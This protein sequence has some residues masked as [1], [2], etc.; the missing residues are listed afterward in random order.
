MMAILP[1]LHAA[2]SKESG[3]GAVMPAFG[4]VEKGSAEVKEN[5]EEGGGVRMKEE[6][7]DMQ[8]KEEGGNMHVKE[9]EEEEEEKE[10][11]TEEE[12][13]EEEQEKPRVKVKKEF[14][15]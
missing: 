7:E 8:M 6:E 12:E 13:G 10:E 5:A 1:Q 9:E 15:G 4:S 2:L 3:T 11:E 14:Y